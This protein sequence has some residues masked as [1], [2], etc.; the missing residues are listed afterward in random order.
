MIM[1]M[2]FI[3]LFSFPANYGPEK[4]NE[5]QGIV[6]ASGKVKLVATT[7]KPPGLRQ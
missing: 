6:A 3:L 2:I 7:M 5:Y 4:E 1:I